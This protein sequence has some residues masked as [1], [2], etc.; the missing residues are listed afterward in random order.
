MKPKI[1]I[2]P[3]RPDPKGDCLYL[4]VA[5][6]G[7]TVT[8]HIS[9]SEGFGKFDMGLTGTRNQD[10]Y[11]EKYPDGYE[12]EWVP[13]WTKHPFLSQQSEAN[14]AADPEVTKEVT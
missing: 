13:D 3:A 7:A 10:K 11:A 9:S 14:K 8:S 4:A 12:L 5:E 2:F 1:Y 6:D